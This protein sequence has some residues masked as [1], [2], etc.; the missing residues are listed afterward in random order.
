LNVA[1]FSLPNSEIKL[2]P[3]EKFP[4]KIVTASNGK[5]LQI[6]RTEWLRI[7]SI[8]GWIKTAQ[9]AD[10]IE[11]ISQDEVQAVVDSMGTTRF[12]IGYRKKDGS[13]RDMFVQRRVNKYRHNENSTPG[14]RET[15]DERGLI[16]LYD[17]AAAKKAVEGIAFNEGQSDEERSAA[18]EYALR[19]AY[20]SIYP[21][22]IEMIKGRGRT[23]IVDTAEEPGL[24]AM[25]EEARGP[26]GE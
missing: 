24:R 21:N 4:M 16:L 2:K 9:P 7:G 25:I 6:S 14:N 18:R 8:A 15:R 11:I 12:R 13:Y 3:K 23:W 5:N 26:E 22:K 20:R 10:G 17:L 1:G 19:R